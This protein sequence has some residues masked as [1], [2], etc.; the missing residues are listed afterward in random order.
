MELM[1]I[2]QWNPGIQTTPYAMMN[3]PYEDPAYLGNG[4]F[5]TPHG[6]S[7]KWQFFGKMINTPGILEYFGR[8]RFGSSKNLGIQPKKK[9]SL[10]TNSNDI[11][12]G[13]RQKC[14]TT[15][16]CSLLVSTHPF[17]GIVRVIRDHSWGRQNA[18]WLCTRQ[19]GYPKTSPKPIASDWRPPSSHLETGNGLQ[20]DIQTNHYKQQNH[21]GQC[22]FG[23]N[24]GARNLVYHLSSNKAVAK[25]VSSNLSSNQPTNGKRTSM[26]GHLMFFSKNT[27]IDL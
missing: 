17:W 13:I 6:T 7:P 19:R 16:G 9:T 20:E 12:M 22:P 1:E 2:H 23:K 25:G 5:G 11:A 27:G 26:L 15:N 10:S 3:I 14:D 4:R 8:S 24:R 18:A 21:L